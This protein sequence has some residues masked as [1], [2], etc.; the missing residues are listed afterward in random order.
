MHLHYK[1]YTTCYD[2]LNNSCINKQRGS[3]IYKNIILYFYSSMVTLGTG[4]ESEEP[5]EVGTNTGNWVQSKINIFLVLKLPH[6]PYPMLVFH[7]SW[8]TPMQ[9]LFFIG[10]GLYP[11]EACSRLVKAYTYAFLVSSLLILSTAGCISQLHLLGS[12]RVKV[13]YYI[14]TWAI[15]NNL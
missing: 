7:W 1:S 13:I 6:D 10:H 14:K 4:E 8:L 9:C 2:Y 3:R 11:C 12:S 5:P 15:N